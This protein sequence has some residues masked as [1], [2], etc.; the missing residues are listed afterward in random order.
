MPSPR[1]P[2]VLI[3][4]DDAQLR[5]LYRAALTVAGYVVIAV[6]DGVD[7]LRHLDATGPDAV[8]LDLG[9][10][11][12]HGR[13][14]QR[15][16]A[17]HSETRAIPIIVVT[18]SETDDLNASDYACILRKPIDLHTLVAAVQRCLNK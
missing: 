12:L 1:R 13:D 2:T 16:I 11:R 14:V 3:V 10:P 8:V 6:E 5:T 4:E 9:L 7:A 15:E 17:S 18:G